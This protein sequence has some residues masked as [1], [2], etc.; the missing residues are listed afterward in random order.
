MNGLELDRLIC[1][2]GIN[3]NEVA[4]LVGIP[5]HRAIAMARAY[6]DEPIE[7]HYPLVSHLTVDI[8]DDLSWLVSQM[9]EATA[10]RQLGEFLWNELH[11]RGAGYVAWWVMNFR[12]KDRPSWIREKEQTPT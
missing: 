10:K 1:E 8:L 3:D 6:P 7:S 2:L 4:L 12:R 5:M 11:T 9:D